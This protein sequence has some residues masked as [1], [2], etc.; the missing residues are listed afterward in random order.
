MK[1]FLKSA[2]IQP[3]GCACSEIENCKSG[4]F[5]NIEDWNSPKPFR[6]LGKRENIL[7]RHYS[8]LL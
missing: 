4:H 8:F 2:E 7:T 6:E 3:I 5:F 1:K